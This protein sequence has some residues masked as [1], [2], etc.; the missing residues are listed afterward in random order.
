V[1][2]R[3][4]NGLEVFHLLEL[5]DAGVQTMLRTFVDAD[6][7]GLSDID[8]VSE[9]AGPIDLGSR[10]EGDVQLHL[11]Y[12]GDDDNNRTGIMLIDN[13]TGQIWVTPTDSFT[14]PS[15]PFGA[16]LTDTRI[17][18]LGGGFRFIAA[19]I[20]ANPETGQPAR[21][22]MT[23]VTPVVATYDSSAIALDFFGPAP[24]EVVPVGTSTLG[25]L[26]GVAPELSVR[27]SRLGMDN[28]NTFLL[29]WDPVLPATLE[30]ISNL[31]TENWSPVEVGTDGEYVVD[32][33]LAEKRFYRFI[34]PD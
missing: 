30:S 17:T 33:Q 9:V 19:V 14:L 15:S 32:M 21:V 3:F 10:E 20:P 4:E 8:P 25:T 5:D 24:G 1:T 6:R 13:P 11:F 31:V 34:V 2:T 18:D 27:L 16:V 7:D 26:L 22:I 23:S 12:P 29:F 28:V